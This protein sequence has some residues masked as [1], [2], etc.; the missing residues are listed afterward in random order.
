MIVEPEYA[1]ACR[2]AK[3]RP[4]PSDEPA[5]ARTLRHPVI[6]AAEPQA[7]VSSARGS[8]HRHFRRMKTMPAGFP[9]LGDAARTVDPVCGDGM[10]VSVTAVLALR[11]RLS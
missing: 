6:A 1:A 5:F 8:R 11:D 2:R 9:A 3:R 7:P 4:P 10:A